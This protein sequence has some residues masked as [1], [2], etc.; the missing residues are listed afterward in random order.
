MLEGESTKWKPQE[1]FR[2]TKKSWDSFNKPGSK[3]ATPLIL[4]AV[5]AKKKNPQSAQFTNSILKSLTG[6]ET[7]S[8]TDMHG[9]GLRSKLLWNQFKYSV[10][11][12]MDNINE[13][14]DSMKRSSK[15]D[16]EKNYLISFLKKIHRKKSMSWLYYFDK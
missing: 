15:S 6:F 9:P 8:L 12:K 13:E 3:T 11:N 10:Y 1:I 4:A 7:L 14:N 5:A 2:G 16:K